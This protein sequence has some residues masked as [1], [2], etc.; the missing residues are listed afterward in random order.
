MYTVD[1]KFLKCINES[2]FLCDKTTNPVQQMFAEAGV[3]NNH[4]LINS[5]LQI[6]MLAL[7]SIVH[8]PQICLPGDFTVDN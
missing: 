6:Q 3:L 7:Y 2:K 8:S 4:L 1:D 5:H